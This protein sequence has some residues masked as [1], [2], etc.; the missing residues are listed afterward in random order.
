MNSK[1]NDSEQQVSPF[2]DLPWEEEVEG[3]ELL[4]D[5]VTCV[6]RFVILE[7][8]QAFAIALWV[9]HTYCIREPNAD[10]IFHHSP[11]LLISSPE[12]QCGKSTLREIISMLVN[13]PLDCMSASTASLFRVIQAVRP[14]L[15]L[16]EFDN[17]SKDRG[18]LL[19]VLN[20][21]YSRDGKVLRQGGRDFET[22]REFSTWSPKVLS[23]I[24]GIP[25]TT[26]SRCIPITMR[27]KL[28]SELVDSRIVVLR[29]DPEY[30]SK[31]RRRIVR[32]VIDAEVAIIKLDPGLSGQLN[33]REEDN[34]AGLF[35]IAAFI[36]REHYAQAVDCAISLR[37]KDISDASLALELLSDAKEFVSEQAEEYISSIALHTFLKSLTDRPWV[38]LNEKGLS[39]YGLASLLKP[40]GIQPVQ[41]RFNGSPVRCYSVSKFRDAFARYLS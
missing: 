34:W 13:R 18:D 9:L 1:A 32:F 38:G 22:T 41:V 4:D 36:N 8:Q 19:G 40:F 20:S 16:D 11:I 25:D 29:S 10:Q 30:F 17:F 24:G 33:D 37:S 7:H 39:L 35:K 5:L 21:G 3:T 27:R 6:K 2:A 26:L 12:K 14:T 31:L 28:S 23:G 15:L